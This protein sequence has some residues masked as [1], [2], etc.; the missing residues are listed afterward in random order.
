MTDTDYGYVG[1]GNVTSYKGKLAIQKNISE[2]EAVE[3]LIFLIKTNGG[4]R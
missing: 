2:D 1:L 3:A 4:W